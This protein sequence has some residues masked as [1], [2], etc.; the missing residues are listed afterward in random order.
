MSS[1]A[2][3]LLPGV[4]QDPAHSLLSRDAHRVDGGVPARVDRRNGRGLDLRDNRWRGQLRLVLLLRERELV[5][6]I[7]DDRLCTIPRQQFRAALDRAPEQFPAA[8]RQRS[9][10]VSLDEAQSFRKNAADRYLEPLRRGRVD[11]GCAERGKEHRYLLLG[12]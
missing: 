8:L 7:S 1:A 2:T 4:T 10:V 12:A 5:Q 6:R 11:D 3:V 9:R